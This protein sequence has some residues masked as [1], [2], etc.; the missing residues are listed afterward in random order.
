VIR[1][2]FKMRRKVKALAAEGRMSAIML[3]SLPISA[4][5]LIGNLAMYRLV[6]FRI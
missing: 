3:S 2:R 4:W 1:Q 5:M 6:N